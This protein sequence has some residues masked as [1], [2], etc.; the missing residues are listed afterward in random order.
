MKKM[1]DYKPIPNKKSKVIPSK[2][3]P[4]SIDCLY[5]LNDGRLAI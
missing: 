4:C 3:L 1:K 5:A 2:D